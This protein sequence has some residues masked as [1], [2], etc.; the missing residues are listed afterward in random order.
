MND[1]KA[2]VSRKILSQPRLKLTEGD[3][4]ELC[5]WLAGSYTSQRTYSF[6]Q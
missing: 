5:E 2:A 6:P 1:P 4:P 3:S